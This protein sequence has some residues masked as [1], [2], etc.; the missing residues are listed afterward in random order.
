MKKYDHFPLLWLD[1]EFTDLDVTKGKIVEIACT[2]TDHNLNVKAVGPNMVIHQP[3]E[4]L[5]KMVRWNQDNFTKTGLM[6]EIK[7]SKNSLKKAYDETL[8]FV[9]KNCE[10]QSVLLAGSSVYIDREFLGAHMPE[11]YNY[12]HHHI[13]DTNTLQE[14]MHRW[15]PNIPDYPKNHSHR[16]AKDVSESIDELKYYREVLFRQ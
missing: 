1:L 4:V 10:F 3:D 13:I 7:T 15:Y 5:E 9:K 12:L 6:E 11:V 14:L 2:L 8:K 16:A